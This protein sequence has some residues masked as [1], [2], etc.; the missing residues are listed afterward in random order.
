MKKTL[1]YIEAIKARYKPDAG[2]LS[3]Y[4]VSK[5][6]GIKPQSVSVYRTKGGTLDDT[7]ALKVAELLDLDPAEVLANMHA[8]R[9]K[10]EKVRKIWEAL[11]E[12][13]H[14]AAAGVMLAILATMGISAFPAPS[15]ASTRSLNE[16][17]YTLCEVTKGVRSTAR[18]AAMGAVGVDLRN[19]YAGNV[20]TLRTLQLLARLSTEDAA[21]ACL[22]SSEICRRW[23]SDRPSNSTA[24]RLLAILGWYLPWPGWEDLAFLAPRSHPHARHSCCSITAISEPA[25]KPL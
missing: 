23:R 7:T 17:G 16:T 18:P 10:D 19:G 3:D 2:E 12:H 15:M 5:L 4:R 8:E 11:A 13:L 1:D 22:V 25:S 9:A 6:L 14:S 24:V 21:Q 20:T